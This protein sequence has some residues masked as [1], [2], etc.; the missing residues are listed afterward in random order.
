MSPLSPQLTHTLLSNLLTSERRRNETL[1]VKHKFPAL[2]HMLA[3]THCHL[4]VSGERLFFFFH[5]YRETS[6]IPSGK[7]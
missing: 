4:F 2:Y 1:G 5:S 6:G 3:F 7:S